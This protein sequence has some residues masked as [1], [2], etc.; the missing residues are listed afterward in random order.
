MAWRQLPRPPWPFPATRNDC[1]N[2]LKQ[3]GLKL[4]NNKVM[5]DDR[6]NQRELNQAQKLK[7][8]TIDAY[9]SQVIGQCCHAFK[10]RQVSDLH[11][12]ITTG[13]AEMDQRAQI[14]SAGAMKAVRYL[15][16]K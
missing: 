14:T 9:F 12:I 13:A 2:A 10:S 16:G 3:L 5:Q 4:G 7:R 15:T 8:D 1:L 6:L 11:S